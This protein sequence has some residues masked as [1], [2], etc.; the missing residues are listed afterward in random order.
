MQLLKNKTKQVYYLYKRWG[1]V[2]VDDV[3]GSK[4]DKMGVVSAKEEFASK[5][6]ECTGGWFV[7]VLF[8]FSMFY[9]FFWSRR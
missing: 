4:D 6:L 3:G 9:V 1:R 2:G 5:F 8:F 7:C